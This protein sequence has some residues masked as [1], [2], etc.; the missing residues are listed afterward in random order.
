MSKAISLASSLFA[1]VLS[2]CTATM[3]NGDVFSS[4]FTAYPVGDDGFYANFMGNSSTTPETI[5]AYWLYN[6]AVLAL[7][8]GYDGFQVGSASIDVSTPAYVPPT[9]TGSNP[10]M[11]GA[12]PYVTTALADWLAFKLVSGS[13]LYDNIR[14]VKKPFRADPPRVFDAAVVKTALEP[15]VTGKKCSRGNI[16]PH[17]RLLEASRGISRD[18]ERRELRA[19]RHGW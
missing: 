13:A 6:C 18:V 1:I 12:V 11:L 15:Y 19:L 5:Q 4:G 16:C 17:P 10:P 3:Q 8:E 2:S 7:S 9:I 14:V